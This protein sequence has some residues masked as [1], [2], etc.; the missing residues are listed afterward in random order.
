M[1]TEVLRV[2]M[3]SLHGHNRISL[4]FRFWEGA[5]VLDAGSYSNIHFLTRFIY[6]CHFGER[7]VVF[8]GFS[9]NQDS[10]DGNLQISLDRVRCGGKNCYNAG[11][12][13]A[14]GGLSGNRFGRGPS[15]RV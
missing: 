5:Q 9:D 1:R 8:V 2:S 3:L 14:Q 7:E 15:C 10:A 13:R 6:R 12:Y 11:R 4:N